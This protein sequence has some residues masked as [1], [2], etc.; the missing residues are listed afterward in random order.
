MTEGG[1]RGNRRKAMFYVTGDTHGNQYKWMEQIDMFLKPGDMILITGDFGV[2]FWNGRYWSEEMFFDW[3]EKQPYTVLFCDGNHCDF[4]KLDSYPVTEWNSGK[5]HFLRKNL[6]HLM[7]GEVYQINDWRFFVMGGGYSLDKY[8]RTE[9]VSWWPQEM[10]SAK[11]YENARYNLARFE[12]TVDYIITHTAPG[13][14]VYHMSTIRRL[15]IQRNVM[16]ERE[17]TTFLDYVQ[18]TV[19]YKYWYFGHFHIDL[20]LWRN[21]I[22]TFST[23]REVENSRIVRQWESYEG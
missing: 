2:G 20:E 8:R 9:G 22:A 3:L 7:R 6:I 21:Q 12:N 10:P 5:V 23:I 18:A 15:G 4:N 17:L 19:Q 13:E 16:E 11:E 1:Q 14:T